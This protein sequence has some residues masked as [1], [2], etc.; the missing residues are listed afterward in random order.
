MKFFAKLL[1]VAA[2]LAIACSTDFTARECTRDG[3]CGTGLVCVPAG[4]SVNNAIVTQASCVL[5]TNAP[6]RIGMSAPASG[7]NQDLGNEMSQGIQLA[8]KEQNDKGGVRG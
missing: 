1:L 6:L 2:P 7:P 4:Q 3:D 8:F 5:P